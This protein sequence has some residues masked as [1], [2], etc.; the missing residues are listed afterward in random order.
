MKVNL[1][2]FQSVF[3]SVILIFPLVIFADEQN[4]AQD[5]EQWK[6]PYFIKKDLYDETMKAQ[7][8]IDTYFG[9]GDNYEQAKK[10]IEQVLEKDKSYVPA[11]VQAARLI[12]GTGWKFAYEFESGTLNNSAAILQEAIKID[13]EYADSYVLLG[14]V[15]TMEK[16]YKEADEQFAI[17]SKIGTN[18]PWLWNNSAAVYYSRGEYKRA[19]EMYSEIFKKGVGTTDQDRKSYMD[20]LRVLMSIAYKYNKINAIYDYAEE[21]ENS[22]NPKDAW[23]IGGA[24]TNLCM[25]G[26]FEKG[27]ELL[28][29]AL[30]IMNYGNGRWSLS[31]CLYG[32]MAEAMEAENT[33]L[34]E[35]YFKQAFQLNPNI[36]KISKK[37]KNSSI[38]LKEL[39]PFIDKKM[40]EMLQKQPEIEPDRTSKT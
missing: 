33:A 39:S 13:P 10:H 1:K 20:A 23:S 15:Y 7:I 14:H 34:A 6:L 36:M 31:I 4:P 21:V 11:Y 9:Q 22:A 25:V 19:Y 2:N 38:R 5:I 18:N 16:K 12:I 32:S 40:E 3:I 27:A 17:A 28:I 26:K 8:Q 35:L 37:F 24:G 30:R 29:K